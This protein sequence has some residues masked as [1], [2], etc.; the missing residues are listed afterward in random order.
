MS[1]I[2]PFLWFDTEAE[3]AARFYVSVFPNSRITKVTRYPKSAEQ[4]SGKTPGSVMV[5]AFELDGRPFTAL[6]GGPQF[7]FTEAVS[8]VA[9]CET[10]A[11]IDRV[12]DALT[13]DGGKPGRCGWLKDKY[14][15][16]WQVVPVKLLEGLDDPARAERMMAAV[17]QMTK[18]D[19]AA[20]TRA[21][22]G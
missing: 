9:D 10:Q 12:W 7:P 19:I 20:L 14:G 15:F 13:A 6:N 17:M 3:E 2:T 18:F 4:A 16:S 8:L 1:M 11:E 22:E 21:A 5:V